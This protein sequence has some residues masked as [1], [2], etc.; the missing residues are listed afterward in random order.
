MPAEWFATWFDSPYYHVLYQSHDDKEAQ[1]F[2]DK[3]LIALNL[4]LRARVLDLA[5]GK[6]RHA[7]YLAEKGF[8]V[9]GLDI[10]PASITFARHFEHKRLAFFQHD[11]RLPYRFNYFDGIV[12][13]FTS[14]GYFD[15]DRDHLRTLANVAKG[16]KPGGVFLLDFFNAEQVRRNLVRHD[17]KT[18]DGITFH[19]HKAIRAG[20]V[21][22]RVEFE[23]G[24]RKFVFRERVR[25]FSLADFLTMF[26][27]V[28]LELEHTFGDYDLSP[29]SS[30]VSKRLILIAKKPF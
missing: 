14:F 9:T 17:I 18:L 30:A 22:K 10:S 5:C 15:T 29:F 23:T 19:L 26:A 13:M 21:Y 6:G 25:L 2:I 24:G 12:N 28:G 27:A 3:L 11:M 8:D 20:R 1:Q 16:L 7:R 4:P